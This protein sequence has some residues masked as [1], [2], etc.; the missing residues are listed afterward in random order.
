[1]LRAD[2]TAE[3]QTGESCAIVCVHQETTHCLICVFYSRTFRSSAEWHVETLSSAWSLLKLQSRIVSSQ[4]M[5]HFKLQLNLTGQS[6]QLRVCPDVRNSFRGRTFFFELQRVFRISGSKF[7]A[8]PER[9][10]SVSLPFDEIIRYVTVNYIE[11]LGNS[12]RLDLESSGF[13]YQ[14]PEFSDCTR[15]L[16]LVR[17]DWQNSESPAWS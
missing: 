6:G 17:N 13:T 12:A 16:S 14:R 3:V 1:M 8:T 5:L 15:E 11:S 10:L 2:L 9:L 7:R 4:S